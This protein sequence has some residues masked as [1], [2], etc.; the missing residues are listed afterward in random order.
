MTLLTLHS[1]HNKG[2]PIENRNYN[3][4]CTVG[5]FGSCGTIRDMQVYADFSRKQ[6]DRGTLMT[7][8]LV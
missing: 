5:Y 2:Y 6:R 3:C 7:I 1:L 8:M 4:A